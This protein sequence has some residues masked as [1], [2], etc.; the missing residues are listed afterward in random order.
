MM[1]AVLVNGNIPYH[2]LFHIKQKILNCA[3]FSFTNVV[4]EEFY[5]YFDKNDQILFS[6]CP[7]MAYII[8]KYA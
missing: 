3:T 5:T 6:R 2:V 7:V 4:Q 8:I 1:E